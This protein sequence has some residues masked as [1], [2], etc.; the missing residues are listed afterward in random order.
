MSYARRLWFNRLGAAILDYKIVPTREGRRCCALHNETGTRNQPSTMGNMLAN[1]R[2]SETQ[3]DTALKLLV[4][5]VTGSPALNKDPAWVV[6]MH[7]ND[8]ILFGPESG[9]D[10]FIT[11]TKRE[12]QIG[13]QS[14]NE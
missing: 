8:V 13:S 1:T 12:H 14:K 10:Q 5:P 6:L 9:V 3:L 4:D 7:A 11:R 2:T